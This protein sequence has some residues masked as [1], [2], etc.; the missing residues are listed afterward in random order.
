MQPAIGESLLHFCS[1]ISRVTSRQRRS[2]SAFRSAYWS[3][4]YHSCGN[5]AIGQS[6]CGMSSLC[7]GFE[8]VVARHPKV[9]PWKAPQKLRIESLGQPGSWFSM[10]ESSSSCVGGEPFLYLSIQAMKQ[11]LKAFS[12]AVLPHPMVVTSFSPAGATCNSFDESALDMDSCTDLI[13]Y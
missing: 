2:S 6:K 8:R 1:K 5:G 11:A 7:T 12:L 3:R 13:D 9:R 10:Q 4:G